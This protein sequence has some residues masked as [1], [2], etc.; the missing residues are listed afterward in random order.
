MVSGIVPSTMLAS[1]SVTTKAVNQVSATATQFAASV[2]ALDSS[3]GT[4]EIVGDAVLTLLAQSLQIG[5]NL[6]LVA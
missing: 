3:L 5:Q 2:D 1:T 4:Q 6:D